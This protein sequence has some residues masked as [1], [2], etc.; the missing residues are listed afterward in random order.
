MSG[1]EAEGTRH[2]KGCDWRRAPRALHPGRKQRPSHW[3]VC[4][5][6]SRGL[7]HALDVAW[8]KYSTSNWPHLGQCTKFLI[9]AALQGLSGEGQ[10]HRAGTGIPC[11]Q[12]ASDTCQTPPS[13][14]VEGLGKLVRENLDKGKFSFLV[15][16]RLFVI[17]TTATKMGWYYLGTPNGFG[18]TLMIVSAS[19]PEVDGAFGR[20]GAWEKCTRTAFMVNYSREELR[21][22]CSSVNVA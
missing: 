12:T 14:V 11:R 15:N 10:V 17:T 22:Y 8:C 2:S 5:S 1:S 6:P 20:G 13:Y 7:I 16:T 9:K 3:N 4:K 21:A 18:C 19:L